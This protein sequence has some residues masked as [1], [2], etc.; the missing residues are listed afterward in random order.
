MCPK[1]DRLV[2]CFFRPLLSAKTQQLWFTR[3]FPDHVEDRL[4]CR[5]LVF[6]PNRKVSLEMLVGSR[7]LRI[8]GEEKDQLSGLA[9]RIINE[10]TFNADERENIY[11]TFFADATD[12]GLIDPVLD[13][14]GQGLWLH[15]S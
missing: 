15:L 8:T 2:F 12:R 10:I 11:Q 1:M 7:Q 3:R 6:G 5:G 9:H 4:L 13:R 14:F